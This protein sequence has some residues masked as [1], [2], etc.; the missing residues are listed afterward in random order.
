MCP[1]CGGREIEDVMING[2]YTKPLYL[3]VRVI[4]GDRQ[5]FDMAAHRKTRA[6]SNCGLIINASI[7]STL[8]YQWTQSDILQY[9]LDEISQDRQFRNKIRKKLKV[10]NTR[11]SRE[12]YEKLCSL[13]F[14]EIIP[15]LQEVFESMEL[16]DDRAWQEVIK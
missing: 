11:L 13:P 9:F 6:C 16:K 10:I 7:N 8:E 4:P 5:Y 12:K 1:E 3:P 2:T 15:K 14:S